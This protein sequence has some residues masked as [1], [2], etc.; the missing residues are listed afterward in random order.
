MRG[1]KLVLIF[2]MLLTVTFIQIQ[3][4]SPVLF[5]TVYAQPDSI[6]S[7]QNTTP[8]TS[9]D[10]EN[11][12]F[13]SVKDSIIQFKPG[14]VFPDSVWS[15]SLVNLPN[16]TLDRVID[17]PAFHVGEKLTF[18]IRYGIIHAG[19]AI[20]EV[21]EKTVVNDSTPVYRITTTARSAKFFDAFYKV[22]DSV[23]TYLDASGFFSW[24]YNKRLREGGYKFDLLVD[25]D[26]HRGIANIETIRYHKDEPLRIRHR[27]RYKV[28]V[29]KYV[30]DV[31]AAFYYVR[32]QDLRVG[33]PIYMK[34]H[35][36]KKVYDLQVIIQ[37][38][39]TIKVKAGK[40]KS[41]LVKPRLSGEAIFKQKGE[42]WIWLTDDEY[43]I[44]IKMKSK[45]AV[46]S[47]TT[48][49]KKIEGV[50]LPIRAQVKR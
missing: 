5:D 36:N 29:H 26:Q 45:V 18:N 15:D 30:A 1:L 13:A 34:N 9:T 2:F 32:T 24:K 42:L 28:L 11:G 7:P 35:D 40:F 47:I 41:I 19:E 44:P 46:G 37:K 48:E 8:P 6:K 16:Y 10:F 14:R 20:M 49:L 23:E 33:E 21:K 31:L 4:P 3:S 12:K 25:Y 27:N 38:R 39:E 43:K 22:R 17:N 50:P